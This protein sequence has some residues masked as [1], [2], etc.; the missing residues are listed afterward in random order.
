MKTYNSYIPSF[1]KMN[2][3][4]AYLKI[5]D[6]Y[7]TIHPLLIINK[8]SQK[9]TVNISNIFS[10][11]ST[12]ISSSY[13][14]L[15]L[16][17]DTLSSNFLL[18]IS[19]LDF[20]LILFLCLK[21]TLEIMKKKIE[22]NKKDKNFKE[23]KSDE[24]EFTV[25][26]NKNKLKTSVFSSY[27][28]IINTK[29]LKLVREMQNYIRNIL[30]KI[31]Y[32]T[33]QPIN[34]AEVNSLTEIKTNDLMKNINE[35]S[36]ITITN[37]TSKSKNLDSTSNKNSMLYNMYEKNLKDKSINIKHSNMNGSNIKFLNSSIKEN[38][39]KLF[40]PIQSSFND[41]IQSSNYNNKNI[42]ESKDYNKETHLRLKLKLLWVDLKNE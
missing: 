32:N 2:G 19:Y 28:M 1:Q 12:P 22:K 25:N 40:Q 33:V 35:N 30:K 34:Y 10:F 8:I 15:N 18:S 37:S 17:S 21:D 24:I 7:T 13:K 23:W 41:K 38:N 6:Y 27:R 39:I 36:K 26:Y 4:L 42:K 14:K 11:T 16:K 31:K 5:M 20:L 3:L 29:K 9:M